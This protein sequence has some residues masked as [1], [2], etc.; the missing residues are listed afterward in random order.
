[1]ANQAGTQVTI[2][3]LSFPSDTSKLIS[4]HQALFPL[5]LLILL[6]L[7]VWQ[8]VLKFLKICFRIH[9]EMMPTMGYHG[10]QCPQSA[11]IHD[12]RA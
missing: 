5:F 2:N 12:D 11:G 8:F 7:P 4:Y 3:D 6:F 1:M 10:L 9:V